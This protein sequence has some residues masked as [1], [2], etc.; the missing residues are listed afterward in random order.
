MVIVT[1]ESYDSVLVGIPR[2][3]NTNLVLN[4]LCVTQFVTSIT[5]FEAVIAYYN[6]TVCMIK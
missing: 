5:V 4:I 1:H 2:I 6:R 3:F